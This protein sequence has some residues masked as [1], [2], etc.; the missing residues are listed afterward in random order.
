MKIY[1]KEHIWRSYVKGKYRMGCILYT[2]MDNKIRIPWNKAISISTI[3]HCKYSIRHNKNT[4]IFHFVPHNA[5]NSS[6]IINSIAPFHIFSSFL[7]I[8]NY[9]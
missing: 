8:Q 6:H 3:A 7:S 1:P 9:V 4:Q 5:R 2:E